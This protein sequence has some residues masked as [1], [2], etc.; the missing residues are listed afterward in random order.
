MRSTLRVRRLLFLIPGLL[1]EALDDPSGSIDESEGNEETR[2]R[3]G[4]NPS[5]YGQALLEIRDE[6]QNEHQMSYRP[7]ASEHHS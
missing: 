6:Y 3:D 7:G 1:S 5:V 4:S 2:H